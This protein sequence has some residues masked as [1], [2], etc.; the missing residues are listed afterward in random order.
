LIKRG[1]PLADSVR[2]QRGHGA[3]IREHAQRQRVRGAGTA[4]IATSTPIASVFASRRAARIG[5]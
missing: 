4:Q 2:E 1:P 3:D 5:R